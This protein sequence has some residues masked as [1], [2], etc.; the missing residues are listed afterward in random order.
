MWG[1]KRKRKRA[2]YENESPANDRLEIS[3]GLTFRLY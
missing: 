2:N 1:R 3:D